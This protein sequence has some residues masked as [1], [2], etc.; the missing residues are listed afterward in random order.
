MMIGAHKW[1]VERK[2][3]ERSRARVAGLLKEPSITNEVGASRCSSLK[4]RQ[5]CRDVKS[6]NPSQSEVD[7]IFHVDFVP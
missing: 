4:M 1:K 5:K 3:A 6:V 7:R 2:D